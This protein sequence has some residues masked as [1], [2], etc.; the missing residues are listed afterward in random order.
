MGEE[1][2]AAQPTEQQSDQSQLTS[3]K[4]AGVE[5][6]AQAG[7]AQPPGNQQTGRDSQQGGE[8]T[9]AKAGEYS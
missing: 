4:R 7:A 1:D 6:H 5:S 9:G 3:A 8:G 2:K